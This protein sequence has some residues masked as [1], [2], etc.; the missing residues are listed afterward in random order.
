MYRALHMMAVLTFPFLSLASQAAEANKTIDYA[1]DV[2]PI[3]AGNCFAC[4]GPDEKARKADLRLDRRADAIKPAASGKTA[5]VPG[6]SGESQL[7][8]RIFATQDVMPPPKSNKKLTAAEKELLRRWIDEGAEDR[9]PWAFVKPARPTPPAIKDHTWP[10]NPIDSF[11][12][13]RLEKAGLKLSQ[14][15]DRPTLIR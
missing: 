7:V 12:L 2:R 6:N 4:H 11:I 8:R 5:I 15:A 14:K 1:R 13:A 10:Q 3:L 9:L